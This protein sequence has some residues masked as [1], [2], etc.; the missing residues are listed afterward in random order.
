MTATARYTDK[1]PAIYAS[2]TD[3]EPVT[4]LS[5][6]WTFDFKANQRLFDHWILSCQVN[7]LLDESYNTYVETFYDQSGAGTL[8]KYPGAGRSIYVSAAYE[9]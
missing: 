9:Y 5:S 8:S 3:I 7:N 1:R 4:Y 2:D 6:Y